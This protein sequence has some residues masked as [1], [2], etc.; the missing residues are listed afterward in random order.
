MPSHTPT[1]RPASRPVCFALAAAL[2]L[3]LS[4][5]IAPAHPGGTNWLGCHQG[6]TDYHCHAGPLDGRAWPSEGAHRAWLRDY[7]GGARSWW[8]VPLAEYAAAHGE[9]EASAWRRHAVT[10]EREGMRVECELW[11]EVQDGII[12]RTRGQ[13]QWAGEGRVPRCPWED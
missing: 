13:A 8:G 9:P 10:V 7:V 3:A 1:G 5:S 11:L 4:P 12:Y 2:V 6:A